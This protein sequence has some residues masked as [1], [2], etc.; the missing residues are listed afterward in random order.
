MDLRPVVASLDYNRLFENLK[1]A[2]LN[3]SLGGMLGMFGGASLLDNFRESFIE[4]MQAA[5]LEEVGSPAF[6]EHL[7]AAAPSREALFKK[8]DILITKRLDE[9][10]PTMVKEIIEEMIRQ[11]LGWL[12]LWGGVFGALMGL[13]STLIPYTP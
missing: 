4:G 11:H 6:Q 13:V 8:V 12:V 9:L 7:E 10:T 1:K 2:I 3:S 5:I